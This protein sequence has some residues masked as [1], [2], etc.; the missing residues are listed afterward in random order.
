ME[1]H[2]R[3]GTLDDAQAVLAEARRELEHLRAV[4]GAR[5]EAR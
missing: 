1:R 4:L 5:A 2:G 3:L